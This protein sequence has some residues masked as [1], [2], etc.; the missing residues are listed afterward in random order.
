MPVSASDIAVIK[1]M[2]REAVR[3]QRR[4]PFTAFSNRVR[5]LNYGGSYFFRVRGSASG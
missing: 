1:Q 3:A 2:T 4:D 5:E